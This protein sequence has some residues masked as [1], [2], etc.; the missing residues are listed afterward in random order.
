L[1]IA[2]IIAA[3]YLL[4]AIVFYGVLIEHPEEFDD[5][6]AGLAVRASYPRA[7]ERQIE[8]AL[9]HAH[10][11]MSLLVAAIWPLLAALLSMAI[12]VAIY[13]NTRTRK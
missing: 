10:H 2:V 8:S 12:P 11:R 4:V 5:S 9:R 6:A 7:S 13:R 3:G 1:S